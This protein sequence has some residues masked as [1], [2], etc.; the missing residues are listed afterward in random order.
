MWKKRMGCLIPIVILGMIGIETAWAAGREIVEPQYIYIKNIICR[1]E[2]DGD[3]AICEGQGRS[4][5]AEGTTHILV[6]LQRRMI[7]STKWSEVCHWK[8]SAKGVV[9]A[10]VDEKKGVSS[11]YEYRLKVK[12]TVSDSEGVILETETKYSSIR[13]VR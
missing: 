8:A 13:T 3:Q 2:I 11:G 10:M 12:C 6:T 5:H 7:G 1:L 4:G 9:K